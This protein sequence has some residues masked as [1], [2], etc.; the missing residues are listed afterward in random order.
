MKLWFDYFRTAVDLQTCMEYLGKQT[1]NDTCLEG[2]LT[3]SST[4]GIKQYPHN[5]S[6]WSYYNEYVCAYSSIYSKLSVGIEQLY[7]GSLKGHCNENEHAWS[8]T[9]TDIEGGR[10][11]LIHKLLSILRQILTQI[12][13][14][15]NSDCRYASNSKPIHLIVDDYLS[16]QSCHIKCNVS[17]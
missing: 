12:L 6:T 8:M 3:W 16:I 10:E 9:R 11:H 15:R 17:D 4:I 7:V 5:E 13:T 14:T 2:V 1:T